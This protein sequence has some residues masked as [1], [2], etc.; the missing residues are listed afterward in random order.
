MPVAVRAGPV[1]RWRPVADV[2]AGSVA[3]GCRLAGRLVAR[4]AG[5]KVGVFGVG[6]VEGIRGWIGGV[7]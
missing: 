5:R 1:G 6:L 3:A 7:A 2:Q 4:L